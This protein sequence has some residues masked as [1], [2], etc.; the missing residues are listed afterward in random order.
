VVQNTLIIYPKSIELSDFEYIS[1]DDNYVYGNKK[2]W[3]KLNVEK[4][5]KKWIF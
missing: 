3:K 1:F 5:R 4:Y 2:I